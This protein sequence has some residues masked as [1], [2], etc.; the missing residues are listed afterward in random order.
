MKGVV[1]RRVPQRRQRAQPGHFWRLAVVF[2]GNQRLVRQGAKSI[3]R[4]PQ[5][6]QRPFDMRK[7]A[8]LPDRISIRLV[9]CLA[10]HHSLHAL[11]R[12]GIKRLAQ[13]LIIGRR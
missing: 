7:R 9:A 1:I 10:L 11:A 13:R 12:L 4:I 5:K 6:A 8:P 3:Q 2:H